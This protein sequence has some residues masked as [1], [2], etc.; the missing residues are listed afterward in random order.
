[1]TKNMG[2]LQ[3]TFHFTG[4]NFRGGGRGRQDAKMSKGFAILIALYMFVPD[5]CCKLVFL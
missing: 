5:F 3:G 4:I 2:V 1:M